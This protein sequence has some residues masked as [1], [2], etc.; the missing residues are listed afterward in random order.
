LNP[1][2]QAPDEEKISGT[3]VPHCVGT[4]GGIGPGVRGC[5]NATGELIGEI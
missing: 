2:D 1:L 4:S 3:Q 5:E